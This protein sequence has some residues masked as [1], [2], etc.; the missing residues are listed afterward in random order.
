MRVRQTVYINLAERAPK[1]INGYW[2]EWIDGQWVNTGERSK[3]EDGKD[4]SNFLIFDFWDATIE[5]EITIAGVPVV[6]RADNTQ[7]K[8]TAYKLIVPKSTK[9][10]FVS[11][12]WKAIETVDFM[13]MQEAYIRHLQ[14]KLITAERIEAL[15]I[16]TSNLEVIDGAKIGWFDIQN[17]GLT[18]NVSR[19]E[20][21]P[22]GVYV[23]VNSSVRLSTGGLTVYNSYGGT[24]GHPEVVSWESSITSARIKMGDVELRRDGIYI[25]GVKRL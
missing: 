22:S 12:E 10:T 18:A 4:G 13:F 25:H 2:H 8:F 1:V 24:A 19:M 23:Q 3:G 6:K 14:A 5:Y 21:L 11:S 20:H 9:G 16:R 15:D 7:P 17:G